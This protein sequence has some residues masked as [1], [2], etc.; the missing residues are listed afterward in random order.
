MS[1]KRIPPAPVEEQHGTPNWWRW[2]NTLTGVISE[3]V[4]YEQT[5]TPV[6]VAAN[7][8]A[9]QTF[10]VTGVDLND[11]LF[12]VTIPSHTA[13]VGIVNT[14]VSA[15]NQIAIT[16]MNTT[17]GGVVPASGTYKILVLRG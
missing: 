12:D 14:R 8:T 16:F 2:Y 13:G 17:G 9:E 4:V 11:Y 15:A 7:T 3:V 5:L 6:S 10:T 1:L